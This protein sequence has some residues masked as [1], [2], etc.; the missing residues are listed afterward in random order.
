MNVVS[1]VI[2]IV[3]FHREQETTHLREVLAFG[4]IV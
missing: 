3:E 2:N 1:E 4:K